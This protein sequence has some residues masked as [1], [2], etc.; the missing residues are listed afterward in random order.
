M[1]RHKRSGF[2]LIELLVVIAIIAVLIALLLPAVQAAREAARRT[3]CRNNLKQMGVAEHNYHD[4]SNSFTPAIT[5]APFTTWPTCSGCGKYKTGCP[6]NV[7]PCCPAYQ[8]IYIFNSDF[9]YWGERLL[10]F[11]EANSVYNQINFNVWMEPP[12]CGS[13]FNCCTFS[14]GPFLAKNGIN[15][16]CPCKDPCAAK[17]PGAAVVPMFIC[18]S[19]PRTTN[20]FVEIQEYL[21]KGV[22]PCFPPGLL[23]PQLSGASDYAPGSGYAHCSGLDATYKLLNNGQSQLSS[24]GPLNLDEMQIGIDRI[25]DGTSTTILVAELAGRPQMWMRGK[26]MDGGSC[27]YGAGLPKFAWEGFIGNNYGG[28][29]SCLQNAFMTIEGSNFSGT[30]ISGFQPTSQNVPYGPPVAA[31]GSPLC[32]I[33]CVNLWSVNYYS[34]HPGSCNFLFC[35]G[36]VHS[37]SENISINT[38]A[39]LLTYRG[40]A[41]VTDSAF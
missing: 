20:P 12:C 8:S 3:Q 7:C 10:A 19:S 4:V 1:P 37:L 26:R 41:A 24:L 25:T 36:S 40:H 15:V 11:S 2:T 16:S 34:F 13:G 27:V 5:Y 30:Y 35:D 14:P 23:L 39:R 32:L 28:C 38:M 29:W 9:H 17:R 18:P 21:C 22:Y 6:Y 33:N 31:P